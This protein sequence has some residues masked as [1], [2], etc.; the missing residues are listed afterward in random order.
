MLFSVQCL[1]LPPQHRPPHSVLLQTVAGG[2]LDSLG[3]GEHS[4]DATVVGSGLDIVMCATPTL[5]IQRQPTI[6]A[7][8]LQRFT[9]S[10]LTSLGISELDALKI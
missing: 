3:I 4:G 1:R 9:R 10:S 7:P 6:L 8:A 2:S 5:L